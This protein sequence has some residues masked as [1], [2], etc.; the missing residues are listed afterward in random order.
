MAQSILAA[1]LPGQRPLGVGS[2]CL[3]PEAMTWLHGT[4]SWIQLN[5]KF[6]ICPNSHGDE[7][8]PV[9]EANG[10]T[11]PFIDMYWIFPFHFKPLLYDP[12]QKLF[13]RNCLYLTYFFIL[14][15][16]VSFR[17]RSSSNLKTWPDRFSFPSSR[18]SN[19][20]TYVYIHLFILWLWVRI[21][22]VQ[23]KDIKT[24]PKEKDEKKTARTSYSGFSA[25][26]GKFFL[27]FF[28]SFWLVLCGSLQ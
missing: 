2:S 10:F 16:M 8:F 15:A 13:P 21:V 9:L 19:S 4:G 25:F 5:S 7:I 26:W 22:Y 11:S 24:W 12:S 14:I 6:T 1:S 17:R 20:T 28:H 18:F 3:R 27:T 23:G